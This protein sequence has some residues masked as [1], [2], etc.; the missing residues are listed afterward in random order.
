MQTKLAIIIPAYKPDFLALTLESLSKQTC[1]DF[2]VY[3]G[4][5]NSPYDLLSIVSFY[6]DILNITYRK[7]PDNIGG[8]NLVSQWNR[9]IELSQGE[10][11][12]WLFSDDDILGA[13]CVEL[14]YEKLRNTTESRDIYH[15]NISVIDDKGVVIRKNKRFPR[16]ISS[17]YLY[18]NK[19]SAKIESFVVEYVF[20][21]D[22]YDRLG[23]FVEFDLAWGSDMATWIKFG[24]DKGIE[25]ID[26]EDVYW[27]SSSV[28]ITPN[29]NSEIVIRKFRASIDYIK[30]V[31]D[32]FKEASIFNFNLIYLLRLSVFYSCSITY[33]DYKSILSKAKDNQIISTYGTILYCALFPFM[34]A[35]K[36]IKTAAFR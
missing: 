3:I 29:F 36:S 9:C 27:R 25:T 16:I 35:I 10:S 30:W 33:S 5:D 21:R 31:N 14:F 18:R 1:K 6:Q 8:K 20:S 4:D 2:C 15:F 12:V 13:G 23:G 32:F 24:H 34:R 7:F 22:I 26:G 28:N 11:W 17:E 19:E